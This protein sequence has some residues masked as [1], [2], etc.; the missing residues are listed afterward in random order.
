[1]P[2]NRLR[3]LLLSTETGREVHDGTLQLRGNASYGFEP[4]P[5]YQG[6]AFFFLPDAEALLR[7]AYRKLDEKRADAGGHVDTQETVY[8]PETEERF[9][10]P[11][12][13]ALLQAGLLEHYEGTL[14][15]L[16]RERIALEDDTEE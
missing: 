6:P 10:Y 9:P 11:V 1:M 3:E 8:L 7:I 15:R 13:T 14:Y 12:T 16:G 2:S 5:G 4:P